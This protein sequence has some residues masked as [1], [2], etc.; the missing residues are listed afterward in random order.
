MIEKAKVVTARDATNCDEY[1]ALLRGVL[2]EPAS[3]L[4]RLVLA[5]WLDERGMGDRAEFIRVQCRM[6]SDDVY[7]SETVRPGG[8]PATLA[9]RSEELLTRHW[10]DWAAGCTP[11]GWEPFNVAASGR[12]TELRGFG[13]AMPGGPFNR[14]VL[15]F[16]RGFVSSVTLAAAFFG[17]PCEDCAGYDIIEQVYRPRT[18]PCVECIGT[19][20]TPGLA[21][22]LFA[23]HP[24]TRVNLTAAG[25]STRIDGRGMTITASG[26]GW[27]AEWLI[28]TSSFAAMRHAFDNVDEAVEKLLADY[29]RSLA[30]L[31]PLVPATL[32]RLT[33]AGPFDPNTARPLR[34]SMAD[35]SDAWAWAGATTLRPLSSGFVPAEIFARLSG[36]LMEH[37]PHDEYRRKSYATRAEAVADLAAVTSPR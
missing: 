6:A 19:G 27:S 23:M 12:T 28:A 36:R 5:D 10:R 1:R 16:T 17:E 29:G 15:G 14:V 22:A 33:L 34:L 37:W 7:E 21:A 3:D 11:R 24:V 32:V 25:N 13:P 8:V 18:G 26:P 30:G 20:R 9:H 35:E 4:K 31:E 2:L